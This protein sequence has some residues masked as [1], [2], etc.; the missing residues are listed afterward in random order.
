MRRFPKIRTQAGRKP[1]LHDGAMSTSR[2][3]AFSAL[4]KAIGLNGA[5]ALVA[6][7]DGQPTLYVPGCYRSGHLLERVLG[8]DGFLRLIASYGGETICVP[9]VHMDAERRLGA[10]YRGMRAGLSTRQIADQLGITFR[11]VR[12]IEVAIRGSGPLTDLA[13]AG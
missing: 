11:R 5:L 8:E 10:V 9:R 12:Q 13:R 7:C 4:V 6:F 1:A 3:T 2:T